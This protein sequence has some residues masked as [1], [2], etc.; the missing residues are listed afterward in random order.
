MIKPIVL[1]ALLIGCGGQRRKG[2]KEVS[3]VLSLRILV[4]TNYG[5]TLYISRSRF[6]GMSVSAG[7]T[8]I[9]LPEELS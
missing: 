5:L 2:V 7:R 9:L 1:T 6:G 4:H 8:S 3:K